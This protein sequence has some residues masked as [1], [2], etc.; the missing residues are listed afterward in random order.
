MDRVK[1]GAMI[2]ILVVLAAVILAVWFLRAPRPPASAPPTGFRVVP[3]SGTW[4]G[5]ANTVTYRIPNGSMYAEEAYDLTYLG[6]ANGS[7]AC[8]H[9]YAGLNDTVSTGPWMID[10]HTVAPSVS[11]SIC[12]DQ[13][14]VLQLNFHIADWANPM[15]T[16]V[17]DSATLRI[18][19]SYNP[20]PSDERSVIWPDAVSIRVAFAAS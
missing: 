11:P 15:G 16:I 14:I 4:D 9:V 2:G 1:L 10:M 3:L 8:V 6:T 17:G 5:T 20:N 19:P 13:T 18:V 7:A 12:P